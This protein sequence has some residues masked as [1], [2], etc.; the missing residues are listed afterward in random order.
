MFLEEIVEIGGVFK[1]EAIGNLGNIPVRMGQQGPGFFYNAG[2]YKFC[3]GFAG[4]VLHAAIEG[5]HMNGET[6]GEVIGCAELK[7]CFRCVDGE[8]S[9]Q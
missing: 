4:D 3:G 6:A 8:L 2:G 7:V 5:V 1:P 9:F